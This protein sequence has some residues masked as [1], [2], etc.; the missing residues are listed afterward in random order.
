M[1]LEQEEGWGGGGGGGGCKELGWTI[2]YYY[3]HRH[4]KAR[5]RLV[6]ERKQLRNGRLHW[7]G[8]CLFENVQGIS[9]HHDVHL[10]FRR[11]LTSNLLGFLTDII[12]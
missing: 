6:L 2:P 7:G 5:G 8:G 4:S 9:A 12:V 1:G 11:I 3:R 10:L